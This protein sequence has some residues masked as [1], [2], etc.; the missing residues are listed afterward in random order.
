MGTGYRELYIIIFATRYRVFIIYRNGYSVVVHACISTIF[1]NL[2][3]KLSRFAR[4]TKLYMR[5]SLFPEPFFRSRV[6]N[7]I[8]YALDDVIYVLLLTSPSS[9]L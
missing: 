9:L 5:P 1:E 2:Y 3:R 4:R 8:F 6:Y 7:I